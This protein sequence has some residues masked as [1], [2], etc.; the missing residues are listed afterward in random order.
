MS[1]QC[2]QTKKKRG[3]RWVEGKVR[4]E[5]EGRGG[6]GKESNKRNRQPV[7]LEEKKKKGGILP[8]RSHSGKGKSVFASK[9]GGLPVVH[10]ATHGGRDGFVMWIGM[11]GRGVEWSG[12]EW[13]VKEMENNRSIEKKSADNDFSEPAI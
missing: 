8:E 13:K 9:K 7:T 10:V 6:D 11:Q 3:R 5:K 2:L 1:T 4:K 12:V